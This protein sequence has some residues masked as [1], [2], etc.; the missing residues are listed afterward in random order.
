MSRELDVR[1][2]SVDQSSPQRLEKLRSRAAAV[3]R[4][5]SGDHVISVIDVDPT[6]GNAARIESTAAPAED[7]DFV[8]RAL[9]YAQAVSLALGLTSRAREFVADPYALTTS[10]GGQSI[11]S[12]P[13]RASPS[14]RA[15]RPYVSSLM[16]VSGT[17]LAALVGLM[18]WCLSWL[19]GPCTSVSRRIYRPSHSRV[20]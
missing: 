18:M 15:P 1:D 14:S 19:V 16:G 8:Q 5:L 20:H 17:S 3:S 10:A 6:T 2:F 11:C 4:D 13:T 12:R 7:A 9:D